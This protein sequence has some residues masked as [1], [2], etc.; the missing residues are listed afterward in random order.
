[1]CLFLVKELLTSA[2][3]PSM[4]MLCETQGLLSTLCR[5]KSMGE[6]PIPSM[7]SKT[8]IT[9]LCVLLCSFV[10]TSYDLNSKWFYNFFHL[11]FVFLLAF[12]FC[13]VHLNWIIDSHNCSWQWHFYRFMNELDMLSMLNMTYLS[14]PTIV[15]NHGTKDLCGR[16]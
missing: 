13:F 14:Y 2:C 16:K 15:A 10:F 8:S 7:R 4:T 12:P 1:M 9:E 11:F 6:T 5:N 3:T